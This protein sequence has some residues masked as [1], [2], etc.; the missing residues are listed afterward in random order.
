VTDQ[1]VTFNHYF[2][3]VLTQFLIITFCSACRTFKDRKKYDRTACMTLM[4]LFTG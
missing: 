1:K 3:A 2:R 4:H